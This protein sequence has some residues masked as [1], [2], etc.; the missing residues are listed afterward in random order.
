MSKKTSAMIGAW[1]YIIGMIIAVALGV[2]STLP[3][4]TWLLTILIVMGLIV[5]FLNVNEK[6]T[7]AYLLAAVSLV[8]VTS[9][10]G[11]VIG[12]IG[13]GTSLVWLG[14]ALQ[15]VLN[16]M[17]VFIVPATIVVALKAIYALAKDD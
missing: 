17:T 4:M 14:N 12:T 7:S 11:G 9:F 1:A 2:F 10:G 6:E 8:I 5:G 15:G 13:D 3:G 16:A